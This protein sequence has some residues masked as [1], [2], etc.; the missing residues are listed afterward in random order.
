MKRKFRNVAMIGLIAGTIGMVS[1]RQTSDEDKDS[2]APMQN[3]MHEENMH[4]GEME[5][6]DSMTNDTTMHSSNM[7]E[8]KAEFSNE[9][10]A[11]AYKDYLDIKDGMVASD[12][13]AA[14]KAAAD[15]KK[16]YAQNDSNNIV[17]LAGHIATTDGI[18]RQRELFSELTAAMEPVLKE[19]IASGEIYKQYCPMAFEG[20]GDYWYSST[21]EIRNPYFGDKMLN[22]GRL[23]ETIK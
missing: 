21:Q 17:N 18:D 9:I 5:N 19:S 23:E 3:E 12:P 2:S 1:C 11:K 4:D 13:E 22:C 10:T 7:E 14:K 8:S 6:M 20:K 16:T 15:L